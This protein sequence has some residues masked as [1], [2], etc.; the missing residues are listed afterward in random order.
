MDRLRISS[1][2]HLAFRVRDLQRSHAFYERLFGYSPF[3][4]TR[5]EHPVLGRLTGGATSRAELEMGLVGDKVLE[6]VEYEGLPAAMLGFSHFGLRVHDLDET[7]RRA[8]ALG[9]SI[10]VPPTDIEGTRVIFIEDPD[11]NRFE[12]GEFEEWTSNEG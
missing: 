10:L 1:Y 5:L 8:E 12:I 3:I 7:H 9:A 6:L 2:S 4:H 11:G